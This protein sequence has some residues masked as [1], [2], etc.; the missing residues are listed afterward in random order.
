MVTI[1]SQN[2]CQYL[3]VNKFFLPYTK[4]INEL[5]FGAIC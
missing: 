5:N 3:A 4:R 2:V 1:N